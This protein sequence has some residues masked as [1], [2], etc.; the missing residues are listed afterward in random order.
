LV[1]FDG[2]G[3]VVALVLGVEIRGGAR[4]GWGGVVGFKWEDISWGGGGSE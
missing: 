4:G 3:G 2:G 1:E